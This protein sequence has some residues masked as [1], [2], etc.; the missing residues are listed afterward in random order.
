MD[1]IVL[2][3]L[4]NQTF[5]DSARDGLADNQLTVGIGLNIFRVVQIDGAIAKD[6]FIGETAYYGQ[7]KVGW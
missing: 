3:T 7:M 6:Q 5:P 4:S 1:D 2:P